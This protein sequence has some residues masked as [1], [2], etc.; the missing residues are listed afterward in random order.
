[1]QTPEFGQVAG[2]AIQNIQDAGFRIQ[3]NAAR[4]MHPVLKNANLF[5]KYGL[6]A[7][8]NSTQYFNCLNTNRGE[9][10]ESS[11]D[12]AGNWTWS[13][14]QTKSGCAL[15]NPPRRVMRKFNANTQE[16]QAAAEEIAGGIAGDLQ[17]SYQANEASI[18]SVANAWMNEDAKIVKE[19]GCDATAIDA[20]V[21]GGWE[22]YTN[23]T[24]QNDLSC[25]APFTVTPNPMAYFIHAGQSYV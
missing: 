7:N 24:M 18:N 3:A 19:W 10:G 2:A 16:A 22:N 6:P 17:T 9:G 21:A 11:T 15:V 8:C 23:C 12:A 5:R 13:N 20:C 25:P 14:C 1:M 4:I